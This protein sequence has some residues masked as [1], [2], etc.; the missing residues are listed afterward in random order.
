M[1][2]TPYAYFRLGGMQRSGQ[3]EPAVLQVPRPC[4]RPPTPA[5]RPRLP[6][7]PP[8]R[9]SPS[10][11]LA[12]DRGLTA[13]YERVLRTRTDDE[14][15]DDEEL[16]NNGVSAAAAAGAAAASAAPRGSGGAGATRGAGA[17]AA[18]AAGGDWDPKYP[19][20]DA[21][22]DDGE[23][24]SGSDGSVGSGGGG[25]GVGGVGGGGTP[26]GGSRA[27]QGRGGGDGRLP[28]V[29]R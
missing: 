14:D 21:V 8:P 13:Y 26:K 10:Q 29:A 25:V 5:A 28:P 7:A 15:S 27:Q 9:R 19:T 23:Y 11:S 2:Y 22:S 1:R 18:G 12:H 20:E 17:V 24:V 6:L 4:R 3:A 16:H